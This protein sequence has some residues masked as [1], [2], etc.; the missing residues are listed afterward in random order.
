MNNIR[1]QEVMLHY[2]VDKGINIEHAIEELLEVANTTQI[3][4]V[5]VFNG[6]DIVARPDGELSKIYSI[7]FYN[8]ERD[9]KRMS[10]E[11][12]TKAMRDLEIVREPPYMG[13]VRCAECSKQQHHHPGDLFHCNNCGSQETPNNI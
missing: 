4:C 11:Q 1:F 5:A 8:R 7:W 2:E 13:N 6:T 9:N 12:Y 3:P 10:D